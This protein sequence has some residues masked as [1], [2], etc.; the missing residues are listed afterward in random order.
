MEIR[1]AQIEDILVNAPALT[2]KILNLD[3]DPRLVARQ[4]ILPS[5]RLDMLYAYR[6]QFLLL[7][8]KV[9]SFQA[10]FIDQVLGYQKDLLKFQ[11]SG[12]LLRGDIQPYLL[13]PTFTEGNKRLAIHSNITCVSYKPE[14]VLDYFHQNLRPIAL[15]AAL[16]PID[17]GIWNLHLIHRVLYAIKSSN[18]V[19]DLQ[20][21]LGGSSRT[22]YNKIRFAHEFHLVQWQPG[23]D[24]VDLSDL[25]KQYVAAQN[26]AF[27]ERV[28]EEQASILRRLVVQNPFGSSVILGIA[29]IV[30]ATFTLSKTLYPVPLDRLADYFTQQSGKAFD[31]QTDKA[32]Y[33]GTR[34]YS[35][36]AVDLGL[37]AKTDRSVYLTPAGYKFT[38][39]ME[40]HR[41]LRLVDTL[42]VT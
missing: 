3:E 18:K 22:L 36:Y 30:E 27:G 39:Q 32:K 31:W 34:M 23:A 9:D 25:G 37:L 4:M 8:L 1:E 21:T 2:K 35:N 7:E 20:N 38:V 13:C 16:K 26:P 41:S 11:E 28:S 17:I 6:S 33:S 24:F 10:R 5:G 15:F 12:R 19:R 29:S 40:L 14:E 42:S